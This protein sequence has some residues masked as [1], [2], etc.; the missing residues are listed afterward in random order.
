MFAADR[1]F[2]R[3][4]CGGE[5]ARRRVRAAPHA[6]SPYSREAMQQLDDE[7]AAQDA[8]RQRAGAPPARRRA[9]AR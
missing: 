2:G 6:R 9:V 1:L 4:L 7:R 3:G 8:G 5:I